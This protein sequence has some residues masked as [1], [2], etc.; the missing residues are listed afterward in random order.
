MQWSKISIHTVEA[1]NYNPRITNSIFITPLFYCLPT[2]INDPREFS[3]KVNP[4]RWMPAADKRGYFNYPGSLTT[5]PCTEGVTWYVMREPIKVSQ[6]QVDHVK[7][8]IGGENA[9]ALPG[10]VLLPIEGRVI[11]YSPK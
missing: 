2:Q 11:R 9:R 5:P 6:E 8:L 3:R 4:E 10:G 1:F 7:Q